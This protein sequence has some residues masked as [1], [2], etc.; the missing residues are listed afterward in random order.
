MPQVP[1][2]PFSKIIQER[3]GMFGTLDVFPKNVTFET[4]D[5]DERVYI[6][7]RPHPIVNF[8]WVMNNSFFT[9]LPFII[10]IVMQILEIKFDIFEYVQ[11]MIVLLI[12]LIYY[13]VIFTSSFVNF[14]DWYYDIYLVTDKRIINIYF[15]PLKRH[16]IAETKLQNIENVS[17][18]V[19]GFL[20]TIF[21]YGDIKIQ[22]AA[23]NNYFDFTA[24]PDPTWFR[25]VLV[26]LSNYVKSHP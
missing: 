19:V 12:V 26:D 17:E 7:V 9:I 6:K 20:P 23:E 2:N 10:L 18:Y 4:Q 25:D 11:P 24:V 15:E 8:G 16:R 21:N 1:Y 22:T 14:L 3:R 5:P 13:S